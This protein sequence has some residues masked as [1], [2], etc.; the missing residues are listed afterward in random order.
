MES[1]AFSLD[2]YGLSKDLQEKKAGMIV[3]KSNTSVRTSI[4][5]ESIKSGRIV[6]RPFDMWFKFRMS[7]CVFTA[8]KIML[9]FLLFS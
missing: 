1:L 6:D 9:G 7:L 2:V 8:G 3:K 5:R 4:L